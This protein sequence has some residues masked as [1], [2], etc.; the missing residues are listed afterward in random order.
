[1]PAPDTSE[2]RVEVVV[3]LSGQA[4]ADPTVWRSVEE[5][6]SVALEAMHPGTSD[7]ALAKFAIT[8]V[9][10]SSAPAVIE[11]LSH[12]AEVDAAYAKPGDALPN[13]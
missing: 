4:A 9:P 8:R 3:Q 1:M 7:P 11:D 2:P 13:P 6:A 12:C 10:A 5:R